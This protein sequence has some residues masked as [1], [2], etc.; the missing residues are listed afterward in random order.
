MSELIWCINCKNCTMLFLLFLFNIK[1][2]VS[3]DTEEN[4]SSGMWLT[5]RQKKGNEKLKNAQMIN[6]HHMQLV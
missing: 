5:K 6:M 3:R 2:P 1:H 4:I